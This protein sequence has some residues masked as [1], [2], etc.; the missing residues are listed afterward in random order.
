KFSNEKSR[1]GKAA[2]KLVNKEDVLFIDAGT[3][4]MNFAFQLSQAI[5]NGTLR[6]KSIFTNSLATL[7][8]LAPVTAVNL[9][10]GEYRIHRKD[11][12]GY[13]AERSIGFLNFTKC[14]LGTDGVINNTSFAAMDMNTA[15]LNASLINHSLQRIV[16]CDHSK[17]ATT[18]LVAWAEFDN[19]DTI[20]T[21]SGIDSE[22][23]EILNNKGCKLV[24]V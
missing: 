1:I 22:L 13:L 8:V 12:Y 5:A 17:F 9:I 15:A 11:C 19:I 10:G 20:V 7:D 6:V 14:F 2:C 23:K 21:D 24:L 4:S 18:S 3:T 16:L